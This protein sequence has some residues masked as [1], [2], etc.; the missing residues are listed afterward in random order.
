MARRRADLRA[1]R[2]VE[3]VVV[4]RR[5]QLLDL[6]G[7]APPETQLRDELDDLGRAVAFGRLSQDALGHRLV[8]LDEREPCGLR[9]QA[10]V[11]VPAALEA[12]RNDANTIASATRAVCAHRVGKGAADAAAA[13]R[14]QLHV[15]HFGEQ[16]M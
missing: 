8:A 15:D 1:G 3:L 16:W 9:E 6:V 12:P 4:D 7:Q 2:I 14:R 11:D 13:H 5:E 10:H